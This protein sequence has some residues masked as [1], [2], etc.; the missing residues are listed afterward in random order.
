MMADSDVV[1][2]VKALQIQF[3]GQTMS[4]HQTLQQYMATMDSRLEE[5]RSQIH[6]SLEV[7]PSSSGKPPRA[8]TSS[9]VFS[10]GT[11]ISPAL[12]SMKIEVPKFDGSD[13]NGWIFR[14]EEF[15][16]FH[17]TPASLRLRIV[18]FQMEG[19][20]AAWYQWMKANNL[21]A[22]WKDF[23]TNLRHQFG[24]SMYEDHQGNLSKLTQTTTVADFQ[25]AFEDLMNKVTRISEP[26]LISFFITG[27]KLDLRQ[28]LLFSR[29]TSLMEAFALA[30]AYEARS[31]DTKHNSRS[32]TK[33]SP[34]TSPLPPPTTPNNPP[35]HPYTKN[36]V[37]STNTAPA[38][39]YPSP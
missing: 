23:L 38:M 10:G 14:I 25:S 8:P 30:R 6:G 32:W 15:F 21:L 39:P 36:H 29:P 31:E 20:A 22:T 18:S 3:K 1:A 35:S 24:A 28:E 17:G 9:E 37:H 5:L 16:D 34:Y 11:E 13:P 2:A 12:R 26:L 27:L 33:W 4:L 19:R 7:A